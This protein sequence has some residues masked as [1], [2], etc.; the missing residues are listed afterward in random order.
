MQVVRGQFGKDCLYLTVSCSQTAFLRQS[1]YIDANDPNWASWQYCASRA[2]DMYR[3]SSG[4]ELKALVLWNARVNLVGDGAN[5]MYT[6]AAYL[7]SFPPQTYNSNAHPVRTD[8]DILW[9]HGLTR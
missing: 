7:S 9:T 1:E 2:L 4:E 8:T 3:E 5:V 6:F